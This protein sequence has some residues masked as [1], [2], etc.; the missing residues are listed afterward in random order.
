V[1]KIQLAALITAL[2]RAEQRQLPVVLVGVGLPQVRG[3]TG[4]AKSYAERLLEFPEIGPLSRQDASD[5][6]TKPATREGMAFESTALTEVLDVTRVHRT[7]V[8]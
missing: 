1:E 5:A 3:Q 7:A 8:R 2:H 4:S 6:L